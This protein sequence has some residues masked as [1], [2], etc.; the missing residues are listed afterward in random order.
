MISNNI[1]QT[2]LFGHN[3]LFLNLK[4]LFDNNKLPNKI[5][6]SGQKGIGKCTLTYHFINYILSKKE[7]FPYDIENFQINEFNR[8]HK[9][10]CNNSHP[11]FFQI[12]LEKNKKNIDISQVREMI[13]FTN[14]SS[15]FPKV[16]QIVKLI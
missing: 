6:F 12:K 2:K 8:S 9:L 4:F 3:E 5:L 15:D 11:N 10:I 14:K 1:N 7:D 13:S 16:F